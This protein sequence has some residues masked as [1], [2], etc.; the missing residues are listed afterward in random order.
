MECLDSREFKVW[1]FQITNIITIFQGDI[2]KIL[3]DYSYAS[4]NL[5]ESK[6]GFHVRI[7][8][9]L[10]FFFKDVASLDV[11]AGRNQ[12]DFLNDLKGISPKRTGKYTCVDTD[13]SYDELLKALKSN[14]KLGYLLNISLILLYRDRGFGAP[15]V[16]SVPT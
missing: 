14:S 3:P 5:F 12:T 15:N 1:R 6:R 16:H 7:N 10:G 13:I 2:P 11:K 9:K 8:I 4:Y